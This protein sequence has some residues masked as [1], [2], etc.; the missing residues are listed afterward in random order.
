MSPRVLARRNIDLPR[1][2]RAMAKQGIDHHLC[3]VH[4]A[5]GITIS[6][7]PPANRHRFKV[8]C[9][10][11]VPPRWIN[12]CSKRQAE[13]FAQR[14]EYAVRWVFLPRHSLPHRSEA[15]ISRN[16]KTEQEA[17]SQKL[18]DFLGWLRGNSS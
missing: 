15:A 4:G 11:C 12:W 10:A 2:S 8:E 16:V 17:R 6:E 18:K 14:Y 3:R 5:R 9:M 13:E 1:V 7:M